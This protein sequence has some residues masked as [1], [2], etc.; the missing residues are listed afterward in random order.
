MKLQV[1]WAGYNREICVV[2]LN[3][4]LTFRNRKEKSGVGKL[5][6]RSLQPLP[7]SLS[8]KVLVLGDKPQEIIIIIVKSVA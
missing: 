7:A 1:Q 2:V 4:D 3:P 8:T 6:E 5:R